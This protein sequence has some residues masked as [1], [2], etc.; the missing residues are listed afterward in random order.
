MFAQCS[1]VL[2]TTQGSLISNFELNLERGKN[3]NIY[4]DYK[5]KHKK[6]Q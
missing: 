6:I 5:Q 3:K 2:H 1:C 4:W